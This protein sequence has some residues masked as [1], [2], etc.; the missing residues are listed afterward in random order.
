MRL[1]NRI[2]YIT[3]LPEK[4][5]TKRIKPKITRLL[6]FLSLGL[7]VI[8]L[9]YFIAGR[10]LYINGRGLVEV[11]KIQISSTHGGRIATLLAKEGQKIKKGGLIAKIDALKECVPE[12]DRALQKLKLDIGMNEQRLA[13]LKA[14]QNELNKIQNSQIVRRAL[15]FEKR[16]TQYSSR[17]Q[18][19]Y[20]KLGSDIILTKKE[21]EL[22]RIQLKALKRS[23]YKRILPA[24]CR[25]E[26]ILSP[27]A[28]QVQVV[29]HRAK[30]FVNRGEPIVTLLRDHSSV[31]I[32]AYV[33]GDSLKHISPGKIIDITFPDGTKSSGVVKAI[34]SS[35]YSISEA[36][37]SSYDSPATEL[38]VHLYPLSKDE[39][40]I[41]KRYDRMEVQVR[42]EK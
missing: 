9:G 40:K 34:H 5:A 13:L 19:E 7:I 12:E 39:E 33:K 14:K 24:E 21:I 23:M 4:T 29:W 16:D 18:N 30:E 10:F 17:S 37:W 31:R 1:R 26:V 3:S 27:Y 11:E 41:W 2:S 28:A 42:V 38:G 22:Q 35:A 36:N 8:Y 32:V 25:T 20:S 6:Y 15:E